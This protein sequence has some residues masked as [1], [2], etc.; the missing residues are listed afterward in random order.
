MSE[1]ISIRRHNAEPAP[2][3]PLS[4]GRKPPP[5]NVILDAIQENVPDLRQ[6]AS[7]PR[8]MSGKDLTLLLFHDPR[9]MAMSWD[10]G[11]QRLLPPMGWLAHRP[12]AF[13]E[14]S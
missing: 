4:A 3:Q 11:L 12:I 13:T 2:R 14:R 7:T 1:R 8:R 5:L 6:R 10:R 9:P